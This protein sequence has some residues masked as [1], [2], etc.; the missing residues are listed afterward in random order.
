MSDD[1]AKLAFIVIFH[2]MSPGALGTE[3]NLR[4][5]K[6]K[7]HES[8][9]TILQSAYF[10]L[11]PMRNADDS[12]I[13]S[14]MLFELLSFRNSGL[15]LGQHYL[16][17]YECQLMDNGFSFKGE[18][19]IWQNYIFQRALRVVAAMKIILGTLTQFE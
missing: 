14:E 3:D 5:R 6:I 11:C 13:C 17:L 7:F 1:T 15:Q 12:E 4:T 9:A 8:P 10:V 16:G 19:R 2:K 18:S